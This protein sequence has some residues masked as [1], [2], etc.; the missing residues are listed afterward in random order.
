MSFRLMSITVRGSLASWKRPNGWDVG[1]STAGDIVLAVELPA[2]DR[3][4]GV[5]IRNGES[6]ALLAPAV[7]R[8]DTEGDGWEM[9]PP[10]EDWPDPEETVRRCRPPEASETDCGVKTLLEF[11]LLLD[12]DGSYGGLSPGSSDSSLVECTEGCPVDGSKRKIRPRVNSSSSAGMPRI[13]LS[14]V[15]GTRSRGLRVPDSA[16][17]RRFEYIGVC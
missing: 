14:R 1:E 8:A 17:S 10:S 7:A 4:V 2:T 6:V 13:D 9:A 3:S 12:C 16:G 11:V 15:E 5:W